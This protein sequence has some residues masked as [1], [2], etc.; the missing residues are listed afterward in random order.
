MRLAGARVL[1]TGAS[2]GIGEHVALELARH[3]A[4][5]AL[6]ARGER[7]LRRVAEAV[8]AGGGEAHVIVTDMAVE[9]QVRKMV[10]EAEEALG[11]LDVLVNN[12]G[13]GLSG[14]LREVR[15]EDLRYVLEVNTVAPLIAAQAALPGMLQR[16]RGRIVNVA[17]VAS[18]VVTPGLG[19]YAA[20]KF[21]IRAWG[22]ALRMELQGTGVGLTA[23]YP[24]PIRTDF[25]ANVRGRRGGFVPET[26]IG[27][28][29]E[30]CAATIVAAIAH[31]RTEVFI[32]RYWQGA[33]GA[34]NLAP[35][36][37]RTFG[38]RGT[39]AMT[40]VVDRIGIRR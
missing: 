38:R 37:L 18:H 21:A 26:P 14:P 25:V 5:L 30:S 29:V 3:G 31:D 23:V 35:Q 16:R 39:R 4:R 9:A 28:S 32:P 27:A 10:A 17:S 34:N 24:G 8:E 2:R 20:T 33:V 6:A 12:A 1:V 40:T 19:G 11:G 7:E 15:P 22:D 36:L 13:L